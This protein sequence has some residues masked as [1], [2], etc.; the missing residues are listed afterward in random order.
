MKKLEQIVWGLFAL[1]GA[2]VLI[3]TIALFLSASYA[4]SIGYKGTV[5]LIPSLMMILHAVY[6][7]GIRKSVLF[8]SIAAG[9]GFLFEYVG[10][11]YGVIFGGNYTYSMAGPE[12]GDVPIFVVLFW[13]IFIYTGYSITNSFFTWTH[14][15][16]FLSSRKMIVPLVLLDGYIV[17]AIDLFMDPIQVAGGN[18]TWIEGGQYFGVPIGNFIGWFS[19]AVLSCAIFRYFESFSVSKQ[20]NKNKRLL[21]VSVIGYGF[22]YTLLT[23]HAI[24]YHLYWLILYGSIFMGPVI[25]LNLFLYLISFSYDSPDRGGHKQRRLSG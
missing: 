20:Q 14:R 21:L 16:K 24:I 19:V 2:S 17:L 7:L 15:E 13:A 6:F 1:N 9:I 4:Q 8:L 3:S 23:T 5:L 11:H 18:W 22:I 12:I 10:L 25:V